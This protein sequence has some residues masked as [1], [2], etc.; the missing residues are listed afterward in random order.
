MAK[1]KQARVLFALPEYSAQVG[2][3]VEGESKFITA[4]AT[5]G[6][7][8][9]DP[10]AVAYA[11]SAGGTVIAISDQGAEPPPN[12]EQDPPADPGAP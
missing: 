3:V 9:L 6:D 2:D 4:L 8:D 12:P 11:K 10:E 1:L 5:G 7:V